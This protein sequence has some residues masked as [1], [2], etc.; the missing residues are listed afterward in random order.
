[1]IYLE[2]FEDYIDDDEVYEDIK[3]FII[4]GEKEDTEIWGILNRQWYH[5]KNISLY[6]RHN[7]KIIE[8]KKYN[9]LDIADVEV[10]KGS[11]NQKIYTNMLLWLINNFPKL[12]IFIEADEAVRPF[13]LFGKYIHTDREILTYYNMLN[14]LGFKEYEKDSTMFYL[15]RQ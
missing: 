1:M 6:V 11:Q 12:N 13:K 14:R 2:K 9:V 15:I 5:F 10:K 4:K 8:G 7:S 3:N